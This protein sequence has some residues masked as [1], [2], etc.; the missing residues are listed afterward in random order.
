MSPSAISTSGGSRNIIVALEEARKR[1]MLTVA[2]L[3]YDG[4]EILRRGTRRFSAGRP[5]RL[6]SAHSG[7]P[8]LD[9]PRD[10]RSA[11]GARPWPSLSSSAPRAARTPRK[12][13]S[14]SNSR[15]RNSSNTTSKHDLAARDRMRALAGGQ[16][17]VPMLVEDGKVVQIGWQ[18]HGCIVPS[19]DVNSVRIATSAC[20]HQSS[21]RGAGRG[22]SAV[23]FPLGSANTLA[24]WV[25]NGD[26]GVEIFLE[27]ADQ[28]LQAFVA[29]W[30]LMPPP[31]AQ[32]TDDPGSNSPP[33]GCDDFTIR[34]SH[35]TT[36][37]VHANFARSSGLRG[38]PAR[39]LRSRGQPPF[40]YPYIN[41]TNC[42]P[43][44]TVILGLPYDR[45]N[46]TMK[47]WPLDEFCAREYHDPARPPLPCAAVLPAQMCGPG[48]LPAE[49]ATKYCP[50]TKPAFAAGRATAARRQDRRGKRA[51]RL[52]PGLRRKELCGG[53]RFAQAKIPQ[54]KTVRAD[55][56]GTR[57]ARDVYVELL[58]RKPKRLLTSPRAPN[59][60]SRPSQ[61]RS[62]PE[63]RPTTT[64]SAS[65][66]PT[67]R[68]TICCSPRALPKCW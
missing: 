37:A 47:T 24:G 3:G 57:S 29:A 35:A 42:G 23:R 9:L 44:Y 67:R 50:A 15:A 7:S 26:E 6:H 61:V 63:S 12:C 8:G 68:C 58:T 28:A 36:I 30:K 65:C 32:I 53:R 66:C 56:P 51:R 54:G 11:G 43:R 55:G 21:R 27:G 18:G 1:G 49:S 22:I 38:L 46:T 33:I 48:L 39:A 34:E 17:T 64:N 31:A 10:P 45:A 19:V 62:Y 52:S 25:L 59:R 20:V 4:G 5:L 14:G 41:C 16:R 13:A 60:A 40:H 2:L